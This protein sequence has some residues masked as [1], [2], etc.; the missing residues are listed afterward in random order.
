MILSAGSEPALHIS[1]MLTDEQG[2]ACIGQDME[3]EPLVIRQ[4][5]EQGQSLRRLFHRIV[6]RMSVH[7][8]RSV[9]TF[10]LEAASHDPFIRRVNGFSFLRNL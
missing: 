7:C 6:T 2:A 1:G 5:D 3:Q 9:Y 10:Q 4:L 8:V